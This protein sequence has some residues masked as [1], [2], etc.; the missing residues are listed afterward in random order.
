MT[1]GTNTG[2]RPCRCCCT[3]AF[4]G[5]D[6]YHAADGFRTVE[7]GTRTAHDLDTFDEING[8]VLESGGTGRRRANLLAVEHYQ[9]MV[10]IR[11]TQEQ[12]GHFAGTTIIGNRDAGL[13]TQHVLER[14]RLT[15]LNVLTRDDGDRLQGCVNRLRNTRGGNDDGV[16]GGGRGIRSEGGRDDERSTEQPQGCRNKTRRHDAFPLCAHPRA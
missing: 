6:L 5:E 11:A 8:D 2:R 10:R 1:A 3:A 7:A 15:A 12:A 13:A 9:H 14:L 16:L 4:A